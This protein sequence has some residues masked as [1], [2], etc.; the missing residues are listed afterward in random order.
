MSLVDL[1]ASRLDD[2]IGLVDLST[3]GLD[4]RNSLSVLKA[5]VALIV[6]VPL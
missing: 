1:S 2:R 3:G 6:E 5:W 4:W